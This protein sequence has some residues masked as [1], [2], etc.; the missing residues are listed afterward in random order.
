M[1]KWVPDGV[2]MGSRVPGLK[3][4]LKMGSRFQ[5]CSLLVPGRFQWFRLLGVKKIGSK[6]GEC[7][8]IL[9]VKIVWANVF[10]SQNFWELNTIKG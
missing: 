4:G 3:G 8:I 2:K 7:S 5:A 10:G 1:Y 9:H 6:F